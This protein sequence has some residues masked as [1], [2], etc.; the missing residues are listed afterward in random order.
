VHVNVPRTVIART[1]GTTLFVTGVSLI[2]RTF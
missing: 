1:I 2:I